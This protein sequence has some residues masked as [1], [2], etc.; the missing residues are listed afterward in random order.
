MNAASAAPQRNACAGRHGDKNRTPTNHKIERISMILTDGESDFMRGVSD[1][2]MG[3]LPNPFRFA[4]LHTHDEVTEQDAIE[5]VK[6]YM[7][8]Y[9]AQSKSMQ[10]SPDVSP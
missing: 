8:G 1:R 5:W 6:G 7:A 10:A 3:Y 4:P 9:E 2:R